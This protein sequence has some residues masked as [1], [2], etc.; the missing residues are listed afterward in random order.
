MELIGGTDVEWNTCAGLD[1]TQSLSFLVDRN[2]E[3][4]ASERHSRAENGKEGPILR[5]AV[6]RVVAHLAR[7]S[8]S[9]TKRKERDNVQSSTGQIQKRRRWGF[10]VPLLP[11]GEI[12]PTASWLEASL[13]IQVHQP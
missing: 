7:S 5:A 6:S 11:A 13:R 9:I 10:R 2:S 12:E 8:I 1:C 4:G 3:T